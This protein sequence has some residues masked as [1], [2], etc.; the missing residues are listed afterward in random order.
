MEAI[1]LLEELKASS[2]NGST[3]TKAR[4]QA[5]RDFLSLD[6]EGPA[7][8]VITLRASSVGFTLTVASHVFLVSHV[9]TLQHKFKRLVGSIASAKRSKL[10]SPSMSTQTTSRQTSKRFTRRWHPVTLRSLRMACQIRLF[11]FSCPVFTHWTK[12]SR[13]SCLLYG[14]QCVLPLIC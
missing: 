13:G 1:N 8:F 10:A 6:K 11:G 7:V 14:W 9:L 2:L 5:I 4:D 3:K 12:R